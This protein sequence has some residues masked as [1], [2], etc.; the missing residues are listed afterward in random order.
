[1]HAVLL[2]EYQVRLDEEHAQPTNTCLTI[3]LSIGVDSLFH[4]H[5]SEQVDK[6]LTWI[7]CSSFPP[8]PQHSPLP[9]PHL[10]ARS[11]FF[12]S[13]HVNTHTH[14]HARASGPSE[15]TNGLLRAKFT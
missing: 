3:L 11:L 12:Y 14:T 5:S 15:R 6:T 10:P 2:S 1:M 9:P 13:L 4:L 8:Y 7:Y